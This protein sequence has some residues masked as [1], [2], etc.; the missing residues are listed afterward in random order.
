[1]IEMHLFTFLLYSYLDVFEI[2]KYNDIFKIF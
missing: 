1:M 2:L